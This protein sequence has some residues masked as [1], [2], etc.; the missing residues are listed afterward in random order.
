[1][2]S[3]FTASFVAERRF[4]SPNIFENH[5]GEKLQLEDGALTFKDIINFFF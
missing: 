4:T 5:D 2:E 1:M 3:H